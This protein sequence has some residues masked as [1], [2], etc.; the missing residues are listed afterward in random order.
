MVSS[1][2][3]LKSDLPF[4]VWPLLDL[5]H[6]ECGAV[7]FGVVFDVIRDQGSGLRHAPV[8]GKVIQVHDHRPIG[9]LDHVESVEPQPSNLAAPQRDPA[10]RG[11]NRAGRTRGAA[12]VRRAG[13]TH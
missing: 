5:T 2:G 13:L 1:A 12:A 8:A 10:Y 7:R 9:P 11:A 3:L 4:M 6:R